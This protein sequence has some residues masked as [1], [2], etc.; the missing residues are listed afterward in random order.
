[1]ALKGREAFH[2]PA[3]PREET[4]GLVPIINAAPDLGGGPYRRVVPHGRLHLITPQ[5]DERL[6]LQSYQGRDFVRAS[7]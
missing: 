4:G 5:A 3:A 1:M 7:V 2:V 6:L